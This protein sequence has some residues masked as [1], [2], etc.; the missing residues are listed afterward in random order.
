MEISRH[1]GVVANDG[2]EKV[3]YTVILNVKK[4]QLFG[5]RRGISAE[6]SLG[7]VSDPKSLPWST[8]VLPKE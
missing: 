1:K 5:A 8:S 7:C 3:K 4:K 6:H 2:I